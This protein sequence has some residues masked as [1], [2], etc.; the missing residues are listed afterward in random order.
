LP[1]A[2]ALLIA[3]AVSLA[4]SGLSATGAGAAN[5]PSGFR[6]TIALEG[7]SEPTTFRLAA[8]GRVFV[9]EKSGE[10]LAFDNFDD[11]SPT[12]FADLREQVFDSGDRGLLGLALDPDFPASPYVYALFTFDHVLGDEDPGEFPAWGQGPD[13]EG[14]PCPK[15]PDADVDAC[16]VSGRLLR[17]TA[18]GDVAV[19]EKPLVEGWCQQFSSH[20]VGDLEFGPDGALYASGGEG[21]SFGV[22]DYGQFGWPHKNQCGDPPGGEALEPPDAEGGSLRSLDALTPADP[23]GLSGSVIRID[24]DSGAG[25]P[26]NPFSSSLDANARRIV[27]FGF[28]NPF[29]FTIDPASGELYVANVGN[30]SFDE[31]DRFPAV[32]SEAYNSGWPCFEGPLPNP[33][34]EGLELSLCNGL[35]ETE[36]GSTEQPFFYYA[37]AAGVIPDDPCSSENG[38]AVTGS[39]IYDGDSFPDE[40][41]GALFFADSVRGCIYAMLADGDEGPDPSTTRPFLAEGGPYTGADLQVGPDGDLYYLSLYGDEALHRISY[42]PGAPIAK[43]VADEEWGDLPLTVHFDASGSQDPEGEALD[44]T[45]DLNGDGVFEKAGG[46]TRSATYNTPVNRTVAVRV[47]DESGAAST[48]Q[49][50]IYPGDTPPLPVIDD[51]DA[52]LTWAV[53]DPIEFSGSAR[54]KEGTG[55]ELP[56]TSLYWRSSIFHCRGGAE[57]CH[58]HPLS[59]FPGIDSGVLSAPDHDYPSRIR[60]SL[61]ATDARGLSATRIVEVFPRTVALEIASD[62]AGIPLTAGILSGPAPFSLTA[63]EGSALTL[64]AP[65]QAQLGGEDYAFQGWSDGGARV[66]SLAADA[67]GTY[68]ASYTASPRPPAPSA[69]E[70]AAS[71]QRPPVLKG[72]PTLS[73]HP[74]KRSGRTVARFAFG[75]PEPGLRYRCKLDGKPYAPCSSPRVYRRLQPGRHVFRVAVEDAGGSIASPPAT[76][77]WRVIRGR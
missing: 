26:G 54:A 14:D 10:I 62:P 31:I 27:A 41:D 74:A 16:P 55:D 20:S 73:A 37:H 56:A 69:E 66:H 45:W 61:T 33:G 75:G 53:G 35:Y 57:A 68:T 64:V 25:L 50:R 49:V 60:L 39:T 30:S 9:A 51:P 13:F 40:Y 21:A 72:L 48:A 44:F 12:V 29:R 3:L 42:D 6:D 43:I 59:V 22:S 77:R 23:T 32:P 18:G 65:Q 70:E 7:L 19:A 8:D 11:T 38:S 2:A 36:P 17:L 46:E 47:E 71:D 63:I 15:P 52:A 24:P 1:R 34:F 28:R 76:F 4:L 58:A 5:L 67:A